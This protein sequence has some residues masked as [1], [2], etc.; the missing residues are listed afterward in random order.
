MS[1]GL[2]KNMVPGDGVPN[3]IDVVPSAVHERWDVSF[4]DERDRAHAK[5]RLERAE[6]IAW[7]NR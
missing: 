6:H 3:E 5:A 4:T 2:R 1:R 7:R